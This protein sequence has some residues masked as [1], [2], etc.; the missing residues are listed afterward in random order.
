MP[1]PS[2]SLRSTTTRSPHDEDAVKVQTDPVDEQDATQLRDELQATLGTAY[3]LA[4]ELGGGGMSRVFVA[5]EAA[6]DRDVVV[7]LLPPDLV[8]DLSVDRFRREIQLAAQLQH[9]HIVPV[10]SAGEIRVGSANRPAVPYYTMPYVEG[11][12]LRARLA[13]LGALPILETASILRDVAKALAYAHERGVVH[14]DIKPDNV[15]LSS[16]SA[17]VTD[18][19]VAKALSSARRE[20]AA[21]LTSIGTSLGTPAYMAPEQAAADPNTDHRADLY[22]FGCMAYEL[23]SGRPPFTRRTLQQLLTAQMSEPPRSIRELRPD[24]PPLLAELVMRC[25]AKDADDRPQSAADLVSVLSGVHNMLEPNAA[26]PAGLVGGRMR[27]GWALALY[28]AAFGSVTILARTAIVAIGLPDWVLPGAVLVMAL[29][30]PVILTTAYVHATLYR[31]LTRTQ[32]PTT[33]GSAAP[34]G[35]MAKIA[36]RLSSHVSWRRTALGGVGALVAFAVLVGGWMELRALGIGPAGSLFGAGRLAARDRLVVTDFRVRGADSSLASV[37]SEAVRMTLGQSGVISV[38]S[39]TAIA[40][41]LRLMQRPPASRVDLALAREVAQ[42]EGAKAVVDGDVTPLGAG[43]VVTLRLVTADSGLELA[44][45]NETADSPRELLPA[46]DKLTRALRG[47]IGESLRRVRADPPLAQVTTSSLEAL[48]RYA[49]GVRA[50]NVDADFGRAIYLLEAAVAIDTTFAMAWRKLGVAYANA[51]FSRAKQDSALARAYQF[52]DRLTER[53]ALLATAYFFSPGPG[54]DRQRALR[55]YES[56]LARDPSDPV[57]TNNIATIYR[58]RR[59][60]TRAA[61]FYRR[62]I[63]ADSASIIS[64]G[65]L[66]RVLLGHGDLNEAEKMLATIRRRFPGVGSVNNDESQYWYA[67]GRLDSAM[68]AAQRARGARAEQTQAAG[69]YLLASLARVQGH[70]A[71]GRRHSAAGR[72]ADAARG[73]AVPALADSVDAALEDVWFREDR[74]RAVARLTATLAS[75]PLGTLPMEQRD[76]F[77]IARVFALAGRPDRAR[78]ILGQYD[79][80]VSDTSLRR[81]EEPYRSAALAEIALAERRPRDAIEEL[82]KSAARSDGAVASCG[83]CIH[84]ALGRAY[85]LAGMRDS[86]VASFERYL[87]TRD[88]LPLR[89]EGDP[90]YLAGVHRRLGELYEVAGDVQRAVGHYSAFIELWKT[91]DPELQPAVQDV[92]RRL[93]RLNDQEQR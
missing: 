10:L 6:L 36:M 67:R 2:R 34:R 37:V 8:A 45:F 84:A 20:Q 11:E 52:R 40:A 38:V 43:F 18:F 3:I 5:R 4:R 21:M 14:R 32:T 15:L 25:L 39:P 83:R 85:D 47:R 91:A 74:A 70:L 57:A 64:Y 75:V 89:P 16:G 86:A 9:P 82:R 76:Y 88:L 73:A 54:R 77:R 69:A 58:D 13:R 68:A 81:W 27:L 46:L 12:S 49:E 35:T 7:K 59:D 61:E 87:A 48:H 33:G 24:T 23:L 93:A 55:A 22:S 72:A 56:L 63:A 53:E 51:R 30:L 80:E 29:G 78:A 62:G 17:V 42:R 71:D 26:I 50:N 66:F 60:W 44:S 31:A 1:S 65:A 41:A 90:Q 28:L 79:A 19:G 92:K